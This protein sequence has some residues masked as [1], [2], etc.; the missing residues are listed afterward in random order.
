MFAFCRIFLDSSLYLHKS[1]AKLEIFRR[2]EYRRFGRFRQAMQCSH[3]LANRFYRM[4][5]RFNLP[6]KS[7]RQED[8]DY[9]PTGPGRRSTRL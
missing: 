5:A 1:T 8:A 7:L 4:Q 9:A 2:R 3:P 6:E